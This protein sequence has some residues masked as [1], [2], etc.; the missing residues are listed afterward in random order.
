MIINQKIEKFLEIYPSLEILN[1]SADEIVLEG[2]VILDNKHEGI[3]MYEEV[4][5]KIKIPVDF[6]K[7]LPRV[8]D[9]KK[10]LNKN[11]HINYDFSLCL[12]TDLDIRRELYPDYDLVKWM[13]QLVMPF[14]FASKYYTLYSVSPFKERS[15]GGNGILESILEYFPNQDKDKLKNLILKRNFYRGLIFKKNSLR[16]ICPCG[17]GKYIKK[18]HNKEM[19]NLKKILKNKDMSFFK[20][21]R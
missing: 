8:Y 21:F 2:I 16:I 9:E 17:S 19:E 7:K 5:L 14:L 3:Y 18:C 12:G 10:K 1:V 11:Y 4:Y 15:H 20:E 13:E 6:P